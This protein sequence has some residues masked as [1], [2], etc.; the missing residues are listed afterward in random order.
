MAKV[1][2]VDPTGLTQRLIAQGK[3]SA[4][5]G[6]FTSTRKREGRGRARPKRNIP[7]GNIAQSPRREPKPSSGAATAAGIGGAFALAIPA[8][9]LLKGGLKAVKSG[10]TLLSRIRKAEAAGA[11]GV[12][13]SQRKRVLAN[14][15]KRAKAIASLRGDSSKE[16]LKKA[17]A[18]VKTQ[19]KRF[20][21]QD[22]AARKAEPAKVRANQQARV[23]RN[24]AASDRRIKEARA[25]EETPQEIFRRESGIRVKKPGPKPEKQSSANVRSQDKS[26]RNR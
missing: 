2:T 15:K 19:Q 12:A 4:P 1:K 3:L 5:S 16:G 22:K 6:S 25:K 23:E 14:P 18:E 20:K 11:R 24:K 7:V 26:Q 13:Q 21:V 9:R 8:G 10:S 17:L